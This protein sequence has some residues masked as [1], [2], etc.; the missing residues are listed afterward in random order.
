ML[1]L[2]CSVW[3][4][5]VLVVKIVSFPILLNKIPEMVHYY[6]LMSFYSKNGLFPHQK[7]YFLDI[8]LNFQF[9]DLLMSM[10]KIYKTYDKTAFVHRF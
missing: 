2:L 4:V 6:L 9:F 3:G 8:E 5:D 10:L 1:S 7:L